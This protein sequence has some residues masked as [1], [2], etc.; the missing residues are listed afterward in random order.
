MSRY[1]NPGG[2]EIKQAPGETRTRSIWI[3]SQR[4]AVPAAEKRKEAAEA[5]ERIAEA[6][7]RSGSRRGTFGLREESGA[8]AIPLPG[9]LRRPIAK[10]FLER[11]LKDVA[12]Y[13]YKPG[14]REKIQDR[15]R[16]EIK[17]IPKPFVVVSHSLGNVVAFEVL[18]DKNLKRARLRSAGDHGVAPRYSG[19]AGCT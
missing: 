5:I 8:K 6:L 4:A 11:F 2:K 17:T 13:F 1:A 10:A 9:F 16:A 19:S 18:S 15:L 14:I 7:D 12:A 3:R